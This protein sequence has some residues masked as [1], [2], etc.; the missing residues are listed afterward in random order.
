M[1]T[2]AV[3]GT[4]IDE[5]AQGIYRINTPLDIVPGGFNVNQYLIIDEEPMLFHTG[6]RK[7]FLLVAEAISKILPVN[8][9]R[10]VGFSHF[11]GDECGA[12]NEFLEVAPNANPFGSEIGVMIS[13]ND[14]ASRPGRGLK[15]GELFQIGDRRLR[16]MYT[17]HVPHGWDCGV[18]FDEMT[19]TLLCGDLF[20]H[21]GR[22]T[23]AV[24]EDDILAPSEQFR[25]PMDYYA[26]SVGTDAIFE[27]LEALRPK[28][29]ACQHGSAY[30]GEGAD[31]LRE[32]RTRLASER[33]MA[34]AA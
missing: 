18:L 24:T 26:H 25:K 32:L 10:H 17:P 4:R 34:V 15:D 1:I 31:L 9:L 7:M 5:V 6:W 19:E 33:V 21:G 11:E 22:E 16:W 14:F 27:R 2:N 23:P 30:R 29:L 3:S 13:M 28:M 20:T 8:R 12:M